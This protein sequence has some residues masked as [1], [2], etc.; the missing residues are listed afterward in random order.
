MAERAGFAVHC[1]YT[2]S[3]LLWNESQ[4]EEQRYHKGW[5]PEA[6]HDER[7]AT[8]LGYQRSRRMGSP[9]A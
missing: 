3:G 4:S 7:N 2:A 5:H 6:S 8:C 9:S 1:D